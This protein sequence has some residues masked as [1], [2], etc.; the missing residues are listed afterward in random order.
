MAFGRS[1]PLPEENLATPRDP[2]RDAR[3]MWLGFSGRIGRVSY[4]WT[5]AG[6]AVAWGARVAALDAGWLGEWA[7]LAAAAP[8]AWVAAALTA[9]RAHDVGLTGWIGLLLAVPVA[10][11]ILVL[12]LCAAPAEAAWNRW[13]SP[14]ARVRH[15]RR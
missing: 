12:G 14:P 2:R 7:G 3:A 15:L 10:R 4:A 6:V 5:M 13:G 8:V 1:G 11:W 9:K